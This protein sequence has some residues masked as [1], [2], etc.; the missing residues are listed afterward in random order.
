[1]VCCSI[2]SLLLCVV[3]RGFWF[4]LVASSPLDGLAGLVRVG[5]M[6]SGEREGLAFFLFPFFSLLFPLGFLVKSPDRLIVVVGNGG[7][8][9]LGH[10]DGLG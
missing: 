2:R 3:A 4:G 8:G 7:L 5:P 6:S 9:W 1:M 10:K